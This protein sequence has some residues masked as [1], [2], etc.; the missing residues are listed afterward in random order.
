VHVRFMQAFRE[1][2]DWMYA[3]PK[4]LDMYAD[5]RKT[6]VAYAKRLRD[7]FFAKSALDP[8][9]VKGMDALMAE[10][11][12]FKYLPAPLAPAELVQVPLR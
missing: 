1:T 12:N 9:T 5:Y 3:D 10:A 2:I 6:S 4:A 7:E 8:D 11:V